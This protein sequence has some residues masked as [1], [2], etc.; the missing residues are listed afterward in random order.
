MQARLP[1]EVVIDDSQREFHM[2]YC[3]SGLSCPG[4]HMSGEVTESFAQEM[5]DFSHQM[6]TDMRLMSGFDPHLD[7][8]GLHKFT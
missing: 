1:L 3:Q 7:V 2:P 5:K 8:G 6:I 4:L